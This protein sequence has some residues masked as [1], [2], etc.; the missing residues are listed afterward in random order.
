[1]F[2]RANSFNQDVSAWDVSSVTD[3]KY[4]F[5]DASKFNQNLCAW[6]TPTF[7]YDATNARMFEGSECSVQQLPGPHPCP[8]HRAGCYQ[9]KDKAEC[10]SH[11]DGRSGYLNQ[12]CAWC[13]D[14]TCR[15]NNNEHCNPSGWLAEQTNRKA[16]DIEQATCTSFCHS[17]LHS[18]IPFTVSCFGLCVALCC[19]CIVMEH[20]MQ[21]I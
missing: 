15:H 2:A 21:W 18:S 12:P 3:M 16:T 13:N 4:M 9:I 14:D 1:M 20:T 19:F 5:I 8:L 10:L 17:C 6:R 7:P 11:A